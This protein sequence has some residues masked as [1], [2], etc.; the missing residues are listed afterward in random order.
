MDLFLEPAT[1]S[2]GDTVR[3]VVRDAPEVLPAAKL[4]SLDGRTLFELFTAPHGGK[5]WFAKPGEVN[6]GPAIM[7]VG[8]RFFVVPPVYPGTYLVTCGHLKAREMVEASAT[9]V[10]V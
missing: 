2:V 7:V 1:A 10:V 5:P 6:G 3:M 8:D 4:A 9:L